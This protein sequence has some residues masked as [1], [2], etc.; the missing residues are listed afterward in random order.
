MIKLTKEVKE[1][2]YYQ[3]YTPQ[4]TIDNVVYQSL[5]KSRSLE[6]WFMEHMRLSESLVEG[7]QTPFELRQL[8]VSKALPKRINAFHLHP[9]ATQDELW[10]VI[11][12]T[13]KVWLVD[14]RQDSKTCGVKRSFLLSG[15]EPALLY[16]PSGVAHGYKAGDQGALLLYAMNAQFNASDPNEG[17]LPWNY[18]GKELWEE[19][20]G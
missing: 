5:K 4:P 15:E 19:D 3:S 13:L 20:L 6:G 1:A 8:S 11:E 12:G 7:L 2:L 17:R 14:I 16:I 10:C 9:K 18:F